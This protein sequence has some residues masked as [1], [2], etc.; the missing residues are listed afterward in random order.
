L[1]DEQPILQDTAGLV[2]TPIVELPPEA[3]RPSAE[4]LELLLADFR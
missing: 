4:S 3:L 1:N 2:D